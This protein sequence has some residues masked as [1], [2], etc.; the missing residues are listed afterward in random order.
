ML[1]SVVASFFKKKIA[2]HDFIRIKNPHSLSPV[3]TVVQK[4]DFCL[5]CFALK[6]KK[7]KQNTWIFVFDVFDRFLQQ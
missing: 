3:A 6:I 4:L 1:I 5:F 2:H 7:W